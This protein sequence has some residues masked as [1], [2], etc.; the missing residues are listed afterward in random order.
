LE[1][2]TDRLLHNRFDY[3][4]ALAETAGA[5]EMQKVWSLYTISI[6]VL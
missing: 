2:V 6:V 4:F 3:L 5:L 1:A